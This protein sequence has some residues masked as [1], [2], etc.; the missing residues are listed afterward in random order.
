MI[1]IT[2]IQDMS[3]L[4]SCKEKKMKYQIH[5]NVL[6]TYA[7]IKEYDHLNSHHSIIIF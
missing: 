4:S 5:F 2:L 3:H 6:E 1:G 7:C